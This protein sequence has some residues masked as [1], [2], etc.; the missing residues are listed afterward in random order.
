VHGLG[1][2]L[3]LGIRLLLYF[4]GKRAVATGRPEAPWI[5]AMRGRRAL[6]PRIFGFAVRGA[7]SLAAFLSLIN[8]RLAWA[9]ALAVFGIPGWVLSFVLVPAG[10]PQLA[11]YFTRISFPQATLGETRGGAVFNELRA[12]LRW[13]RKL[14]RVT[15]EAWSN[16]LL[17]FGVQLH[18]R[19][20][21]GAS[22]AARAIL[23]ALEGDGEH[24]RELFAVVQDLAP[25]RAARSVRCYGQ[26]WLLSDAAR[27]AAFHEV[28]RLC[29]RGP[30]SG[31]RWFM[32]VAAERLLGIPNAGSRFALKCA[33]LLAPARRQSYDL[34]QRALHAEAR[35]ELTEPCS[36]FAA[37]M[38][39]TRALMLL[40]RGVVT[41]NELRCVA[42]AWQI[43]FESGEARELVATRC[44]E[45]Q[46]N[47]AAD[48]VVAR[49]EREIIGLLAELWRDSLA[50][51]ES[52]E[53][54]SDLILAVKDQLQFELLGELE[55][56]CLTLP[57]GSA[58]TTVELEPHW[59]TWAHVRAVAQLFFDVLPDRAHMVFEA[60]G[61]ELLNHGA[62]LYNKERAR[63]VAHDIFR[64]LHRLAPKD[65]PNYETLGRNL[66]LS[67]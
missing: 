58:P 6:S 21:R 44:H 52:D 27:R 40:P 65:D 46:G 14:E 45:L 17:E 38:G 56:L 19:G 41:R 8:G 7:F 37:T 55:S 34:F 16:G 61:G 25:V 2:A 29:Q 9:C 15:S 32:R 64:F 23:D 49:F 4:S 59:R 3:I 24:A 22:L 30:R 48:E 47:F 66:K 43:C 12:R 60:S 18:D 62:W 54:E 35:R 33:W 53:A 20:V 36:G 39:R 51:D 57:H 28:I 10:I 5:A 13:G 63:N 1:L 26:A 67:A 50:D 31:R 11:Y 42:A